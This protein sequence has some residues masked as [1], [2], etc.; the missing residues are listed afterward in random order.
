VAARSA[1]EPD[2]RLVAG[3]RPGRAAGGARRCLSG[4]GEA[5]LPLVYADDV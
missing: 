1:T 2:V 3:R 4:P 5:R